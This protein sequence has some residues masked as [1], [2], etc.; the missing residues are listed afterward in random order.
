MVKT[1]RGSPQ[2]VI[3][4]ITNEA[5]K[6]LGFKAGVKT[7]STLMYEELRGVLKVYIEDLLKPTVLM[8]AH[9]R[10]KTIG[11]EDVKQAL[12]SQ[13]KRVYSTGQES[14]Q[15]R[16]PPYESG[17]SRVNNADLKR[18]RPKKAPGTVALSAI[19]FHQ[20]QAGCYIIARA[21]F[22]RVAREAAQYFVRDI[23]FTEQGM[24]L[25]QEITE[26]HIVGL[27][28]DAQIAAIHAKRQTVMPKDLQIV[29]RFRGER[30]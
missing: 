22:D 7:M 11:E 21:A 29:R 27:L 13:Q 28:E 30:A 1:V 18:A 3:Y 23:R 15:K 16:C 24:A 20:K 26:N 6:R 17:A 9:A 19:R 4:G 14:Q 25:L 2:D 12:I 10:R 8:A 5:L